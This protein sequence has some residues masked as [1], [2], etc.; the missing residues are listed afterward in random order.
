MTI[1]N[2]PNLSNTSVLGQT[3]EHILSIICPILNLPVAIN[4]AIVESWQAMQSAAKRDGFELCIASGFRDFDRQ[5]SIWNRKF[6]GQLAIMNDNNEQ[7]NIEQITAL[8]KVHAILRFSA[9][10]GASRHHWGTDIDVYSPN[11]LPQGQQLQLEP[12][13]YQENGYFHSLSLWLDEH[14]QQYG[15]AKVYQTDNGGIAPEPWHLSH[16]ATATA[17]ANKLTPNLLAQTL[18]AADISGKTLLMA[19]LDEIYQRYIV[20]S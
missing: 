1:A 10:P 6:S 18:L 15:F 5:L 20:L 16:I 11:M 19:Q 4:S 3:D 13:E 8:E 14:M 2:F 9:L 7:V 12:W 17:F